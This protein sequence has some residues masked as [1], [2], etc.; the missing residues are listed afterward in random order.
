M[1]LNKVFLIG[2]ITR[3]PEIKTLPSGTAVTTFGLAT[4]R[5]WNK[6]GQ[7]QTQAEFHNIVAFGRTAEVIT[8]YLNKGSMILVEGRI[9]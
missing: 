3:D 8:Q 6:D 2:N 1:N 7:K 9:Q 5:I 4:N